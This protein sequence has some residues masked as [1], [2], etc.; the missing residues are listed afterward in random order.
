MQFSLGEGE[1]VGVVEGVEEALKSFKKGE[2][3]R[4]KI[5]SKFAFQ[6][7]GNSEF[8]IPPHAD[9]EYIVELK[10]FEKV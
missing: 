6:N 10:N 8:N 7:K 9:V 3:S 1:N 4:L 5:K 2:K